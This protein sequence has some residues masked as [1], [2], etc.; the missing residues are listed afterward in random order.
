MF[1]MWLGTNCSGRDP[2][3]Q[4]LS[5]PQLMHRVIPG[6][7]LVDKNGINAVQQKNGLLKAVDLKFVGV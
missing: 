7:Q 5:Y 4:T 1:C 2:I 3:W 6:E